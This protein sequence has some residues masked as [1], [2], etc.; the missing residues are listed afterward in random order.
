LTTSNRWEEAVENKALALD[1]IGKPARYDFYFGNTG[2]VDLYKPEGYDWF[3]DIYKDLSDMGVNG[4]WGDLGE[5]E[6]HPNWVQ[7]AT[8]SAAEV[9]NIYGHDWAK[10]VYEVN[11]EANPNRRPFILMRAGYSGSQRFGMIPWSG[12]VNRTW[13]GLQSQPEIAL[14]MGIQGLGYMHSDLGGFAGA[15]LDDE[16]YTRWLQYGVFQPIY[17]PHAQEDVPSEPVYRSEDAK[18]KAKIAIEL[19]YKLLP[20]NYNLAFENNQNGT[21][22]MRPLFFEEPEK[23]AENANTYLWGHDFLITPVLF[24]GQTEVEVTFPSTADWFDFYSDEKIEGGQVKTLKT[25]PNSIPTYVRAGAFILMS[26][27]LQ[28]TKDYKAKDLILHYY[29]D[30]DIDESERIFYND[31]GS[32]FEAFEKE[33][34]EL[35]EFEAEIE[36]RWLEIDFEAETAENFE[37]NSKNI[38]LKVHNYQRKPKK[39]KVNGKKVDIDYQNNTLSIPVFWDTSKEL[40]VRIKG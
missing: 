2:L 22:L 13:G 12:D 39:I 8:G 16:L 17:R 37:T 14:Q 9:H 29:H 27:P 40:K 33:S 21:P 18:N 35:L 4:F 19:R 24:Q 3:K 7:H 36:R 26:Q 11:L 23:Y 20:Y 10:L 31:D 30:K 25:N 15:N 1:S 5:P 38:L 34:Y 6:V 28:N 32:T